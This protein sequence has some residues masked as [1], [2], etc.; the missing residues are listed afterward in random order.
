MSISFMVWSA[1]FIPNIDHST[2]K[3]RF[4]LSYIQNKSALLNRRKNNEVNVASWDY[5]IGKNV[6]EGKCKAQMLLII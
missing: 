1:L 2:N 5:S 6:I 4:Y 3:L